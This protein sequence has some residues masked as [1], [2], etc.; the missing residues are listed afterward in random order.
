MSVQG[1]CRFVHGDN[2]VLDTLSYELGQLE[3]VISLVH[4]VLFL[5]L[6][7]LFGYQACRL[8]YQV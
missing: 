2:L 1:H 5:V 3:E 4:P 8:F 6:I 7:Q